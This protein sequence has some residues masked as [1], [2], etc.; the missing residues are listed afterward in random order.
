MATDYGNKSIVT[1]GLVFLADAANKQS[2]IGS[3]T[4][5]TNL[6]NS[7]VTGSLNNSPVFS[8]DNGGQWSFTN[9][10]DNITTETP[11]S[12]TSFTLD[13][14]FY[15]IY[16]S[17]LLAAYGMYAYANT[18]Y[19]GFIWYY[20][21]SFSSGN[22][23]C[24]HN[25]WW[26]NTSNST[27]NFSNTTAYTANKWHN[28]VLR[29]E[30]NTSVKTYIDGVENGSKTSDTNGVLSNTIGVQPLRFGLAYNNYTTSGKLSNYKLYNRALSESEIQ[31]NY[32]ALK[33]RFTIDNY[34]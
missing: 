12:L 32:D 26:S 21:T 11:T 23:N 33:N 17:G 2:Y 8:T 22:Y 20:Q 3:G 16:Q 13:I 28:M 14:W 6:I 19:D 1:D 5:V 18:G 29:R 9:T 25:V 7:N 4:A 24:N 10:D 30:L 27:A 34:Y 31:Q 15:P